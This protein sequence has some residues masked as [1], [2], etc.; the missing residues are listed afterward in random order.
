MV[1]WKGLFSWDGRDR[2]HLHDEIQALLPTRR[3][4][5]PPSAIPA[6]EVTKVALRLKYQ[7][8]QVIPCELPEDRVEQAHSPIITQCVIDTAKEAGGKENSA[9]VVYCL[10]V[11]KKWFKLQ[12]V[13]ELWDADLH[14]VRA[15]A[16]E[17]IAKHLI[18][19]EED[20][21]YLMEDVLLKRYS[22]VIDNEDTVP[23]N[24]IE[25]AV[26]LHAL[27]V[28]GSS[29]Y[30]K[31]IGYLWRGWLVQDDD[32]SARFVHYNNKGN[33]NYWVHCDPDRMRVPMYQNAVQVLVSVIYLAL[34][35]GAIN[36][37]NPTGDVDV[38]EV[39][40]Y[41]FTFGF[42]CDELAKLWKVG[43]YYIGFW[44][45]FNSTL[46]AIL[47]VSFVTRM[48]ALAHPLDT[49]ERRH[50]NELSYNFLAF[51]APL[52]WGR[53]LLY[54]D[55]FR[56]F[57]AM[58]VVLKVMMR[59]SAIFFILLFVICVGFLQAF[60]GLD[61][62]DNNLTAVGFISKA[63]LNAIMTSPDFDGF[64]NF[65][66]PF[67]LI[68]YYIY[69]FVIMVILLNILIALYNS[70]YEDIT[71]NATD[72]YMAL[73]AQ[74]TMQFVRAPDENVFIAPFNLIELFFLILPL[75]WWMNSKTYAR[76]NDHIMAFIYAPLLLFTAGLET[77]AAHRVKTNVKRG[78]EDDDVIEEWEQMESSIDFE[79]DGWAKKVESTKPNVEFDTATK[80]IIELRE[81][82][83]ALKD[84]VEMLVERKV[85]GN[86]K[87]N[88]KD[89]S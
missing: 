24:A 68:L 25:R 41:V 77:R 27:H 62:V 33:T 58:L 64:E 8:E 60:I 23:A 70:A 9:C 32:D 61:Q 5:V 69:T 47:T 20:M 22:I 13:K 59:E 11:V 45:V 87:G 73:F 55:N 16:C 76:L 54:L 53:L 31:C 30:Q 63:M 46:Y 26:D 6:K 37:I 72:E 35:T 7:I 36:T 42:I 83:R 28:I 81:E 86:D 39:L 2:H 15:L 18:E 78:A 14:N 40:L 67:G 29:G 89:D 4:D 74:K 51:S 65:G 1:S 43:R 12:A 19:T 82:V 57:G 21:D 71:D 48:I 80:E 17:I 3:D 75:E 49:K 10:L 79:G 50:Y 66:H 34:Y 56:F 88:G 44:N 84:L 52:F 38:I 85:N